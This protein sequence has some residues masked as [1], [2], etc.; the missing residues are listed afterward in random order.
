MKKTVY[1]LLI[2][3]CLIAPLT[4]FSQNL[5]PLL[6]GQRI[7]TAAAT[8]LKIDVGAEA[9][10]MAGASV[11]MA[12]DATT[13]Y[14]NPAAAAQLPGNY[15]TLSHIEWPV[16]IQYE[17]LG[18]V[19]HIPKLGT[20]GISM[21]MLHMADMEVTT[22][23]H[24]TGTGEYFRYNDTFAA[25]TYALKM[26]NRFSFGAS[27]KYVEEYLA[28]LRMGGW[29]I[30]LGTF[31]WT[32]FKSLRFAVSLVNFGPDLK[33]GG[34]YMNRTR[35]GGLTEEKYEAFSPPTTF[36]VG[37]AM[38][39]YSTERYTITTSFQINHPVDNAENAVLGLDVGLLSMLHLRA[40]YRINYDDEK[41]TLGAGFD[42]N[43]IGTDVV[44]DY[45]FKD[46]D[47]LSST[48]QF[49]LGFQF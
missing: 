42:Y 27:V 22:E 4:A 33:P 16:D 1:L 47:H 29:M 36:R 7:G 43:V 3:T 20:I 24:P 49:T 26:T 18:Y 5:F 44:L 9:T 31:Y 39:A 10:A 28:G 11:A 23:Y 15:L 37:A 6:G 32:G 38:D 8:F 45:A 2:T 13:L 46:F 30:D 34:S 40:G 25:L 21:G 19:H 35:E 12:S 14:W 41:F 48:H 17:Y